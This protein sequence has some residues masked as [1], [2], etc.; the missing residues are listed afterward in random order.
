MTLRAALPLGYLAS[1]GISSA[2]VAVASAPVVQLS[3]SA[4]VGLP[5]AFDL[6]YNVPPDWPKRS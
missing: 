6:T 2:S 1:N 4:S 5:N 3:C